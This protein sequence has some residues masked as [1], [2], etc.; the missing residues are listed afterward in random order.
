M[1]TIAN[2]RPGGAKHTSPD[3][4]AQFVKRGIA[5][6]L[7]DGRIHFVDQA[8]LRH[9]AAEL[10]QTLREEAIEFARNRSGVVYWNGARAVYIDGYDV[11]MFPPGCNVSYPKV[12]SARAARR[13]ASSCRRAS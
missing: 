8:R 11:A 12:G 5:E 13:F 6:W 4:A 9:Q 2:P 10:R 1:I 7:P 3:R